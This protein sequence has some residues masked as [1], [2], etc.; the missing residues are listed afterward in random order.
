[1]SVNAFAQELCAIAAPFRQ[2]RIVVNVLSC[3]LCLHFHPSI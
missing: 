2:A 3:F 1:M